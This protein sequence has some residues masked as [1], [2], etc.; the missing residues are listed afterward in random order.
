MDARGMSE[1]ELAEGTRRS[2][3]DE[4]TSWT[5]EADKVIVF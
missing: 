1:A 3:L 2:S 4:R 5:R